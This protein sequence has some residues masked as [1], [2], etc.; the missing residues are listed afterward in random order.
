MARASWSKAGWVLGWRRMMRS[1][2][3][4]RSYASIAPASSSMRPATD[5]PPVLAGVSQL[6]VHADGAAQRGRVAALGLQSRVHVG[7]P[8]ASRSSGSPN[9]A[10]F[11]A[12]A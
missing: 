4:S 10:V 6:A 11:Q 3:P 1:S 12:S 2:M 9:Q 7:Q 8:L 5:P